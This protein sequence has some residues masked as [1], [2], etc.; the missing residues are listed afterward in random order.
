MFAVSR[1][2]VIFSRKIW[3]QNLLP[4]FVVAWI[5]SAGLAFVERRPRFIVVH[6]LS[7]A[8]AAQI[9]L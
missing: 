1:W 5:A 4:L 2:A 9:H 6:L 7:L 8:I 3:A